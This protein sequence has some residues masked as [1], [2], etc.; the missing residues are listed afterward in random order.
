MDEKYRFNELKWNFGI[1]PIRNKKT[2]FSVNFQ[3]AEF[4]KVFILQKIVK[5]QRFWE[6]FKATKLY[7]VVFFNFL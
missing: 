5:S 4:F 1:F 6:S 7:L 2:H 3:V